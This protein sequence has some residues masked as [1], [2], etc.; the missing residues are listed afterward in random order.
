M[1]SVFLYVAIVAVWGAVLVPM[2]LRRDAD[3]ARPGFWLLGRRSAADG[4]IP[5]APAEPNSAAQPPPGDDDA[6]PVEAE[7]DT[8]PESDM[9]PGADTL[10]EPVRVRRPRRTRSR[11]AVMAR[12]RRRTLG[13]GCLL[14]AAVV[15]VLTGAARPWLTLP[16]LALFAGHLA[17]LRAAA[18]MD[19]E[20]RATRRAAQARA[21]AA[22]TE[23]ARPYEPPAERTRD[24]ADL[25]QA[26]IIDLTEQ[27]STREVYDQ[28]LDGL[29]AVG[30]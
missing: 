6:D 22:R 8:G 5:E 15:T 18:Q 9:E 21:H 26:E 19:A 20:R 4:H 12:R 28:Y 16:P 13:L 30:D 23:T 1:K 27:R 17:M 2:W 14:V 10:S 24:S 7:S 25:D 11:G 3:S 29:R